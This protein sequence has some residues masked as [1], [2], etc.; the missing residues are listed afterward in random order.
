[1]LF[2]G[3]ASVSFLA[4]GIYLICFEDEVD[5]DNQLTCDSEENTTSSEQNIETNTESE[6]S[7]D[8]KSK[9]DSNDQTDLNDQTDEKVSQSIDEKVIQIPDDVVSDL[10]S[11]Y[12]L[13]EKYQEMKNKKGLRDYLN[14]SEWKQKIRKRFKS[15]LSSEEYQNSPMK[16]IYTSRSKRSKNEYAVV[17]DTVLNLLEHYE[18]LSSGDEK[19]LLEMKEITRDSN[20]NPHFN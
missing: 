14:L 5:S 12:H 16:Y 19:K 15:V 13:E 10:W 11:S 17:E 7:N 1:M 9:K 18:I 2:I 8:Q 20:G 3:L 4:Y 6:N